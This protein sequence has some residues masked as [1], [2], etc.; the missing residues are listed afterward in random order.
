MAAAT[1]LGADLLTPV[2]ARLRFGVDVYDSKFR[3]PRA[4]RKSVR[5]GDLLDR[6]ERE[7]ACPL[8]LLRAP[9]GYGKTTLLM[10]WADENER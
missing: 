7:R 8:V 1:T 3:S 6:L 10:Q 9:A 2:P 4:R 5:R